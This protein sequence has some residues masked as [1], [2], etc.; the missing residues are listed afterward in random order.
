MDPHFESGNAST[1]SQ[2]PFFRVP[3]ACATRHHESQSKFGFTLYRPFEIPREVIFVS[4][5]ATGRT[6]HK[7][8]VHCRL[9]L[10]WRIGDLAPIASRGLQSLNGCICKTRSWTSSFNLEDKIPKWY[11]HD[12]SEFGHVQTSNTMKVVR[13]LHVPSHVDPGRHDLWTFTIIPCAA[14]CWK[15]GFSQTVYVKP[16]NEL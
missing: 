4:S 15:L 2:Y 10:L 1:R 5:R 11:R 6:S 8:I 7:T 9:L 13:G 12:K 14:C 16:I 3:M